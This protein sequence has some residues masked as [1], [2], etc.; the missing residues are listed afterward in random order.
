MPLF[1]WKC[2]SCGKTIEVLSFSLTEVVDC[3]CGAT[4]ERLFPS[5]QMIKMKGEGGYPSR[6]RQI[7]NTTKREHPKIK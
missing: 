3:P 5:G 6:R 7:F 2:P 4:M 1:D